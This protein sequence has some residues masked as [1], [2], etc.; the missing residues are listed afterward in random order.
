MSKIANA[1]LMLEYLNTGKKYTTKEL[2]NKLGI[3]ERMVRYYKQELEQIG[4]PIQTF[5][6][7]GGGYFLFA[8]TTSYNHINKY[9]VELM[10]SVL[11]ILEKSEFKNIDNF[12]IL[13]NKIKQA[14]KV[15]EE[16]SQFSE[17]ID[18][19]VNDVN[20]EKI[21]EY[22]K[23]K[24]R[25]KIIYEDISGDRKERWIHPLQIFRFKEKIFITAYCELRNDIRHFEL[26]RIKK[27][28][29]KQ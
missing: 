20:L 8:P 12:R 26:M 24:S 4:I 23:K 5:M 3:T 1:M 11:R 29:D 25:I 13:V 18:D 19:E 2:A 10:K 22:V 28:M 15:E 16:K 6:G 17:I 14:Y 7:P 21:R 9:D 27:I